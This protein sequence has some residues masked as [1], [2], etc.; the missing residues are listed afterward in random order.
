M[1]GK[2]RVAPLQKQSIPRL[3]LLSAVLLVRLMDTM[4]SSLA[5]D[6][7][8]S[9]CHCFSDSQITLAWIRNVEKSWL[10]VECWRHIPGVENPADLP[11]KGAAPM[12]LLVNKSWRDGLEVPLNLDESNAD[13]PPE[14]FEEL[15]ASEKRAH[16]LLAQDSAPLVEIQKFSSLNRLLGVLTCVLKF[17]SILRRKT[18]STRFDGS[19]RRFSESLFI[20]EAQASLKRHKNYLMWKKQLSVFADESDVLRCRGRI[21]NVPSLPYS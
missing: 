4:K 3:E 12:E 16:G 9:S 8:I 10:P 13:I 14:C 18:G 6:L 19:E 17:C 7:K 2:T 1:A 20:K 21:D 5:S 11:S 15:R